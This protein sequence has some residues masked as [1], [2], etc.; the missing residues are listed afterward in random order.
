VEIKTDIKTEQTE[1]SL[2]EAEVEAEA[3]G[4]IRHLEPA[5]QRAVEK[6]GTAETVKLY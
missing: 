6:G 2:V 3:Q 5:R 4:S 1:G